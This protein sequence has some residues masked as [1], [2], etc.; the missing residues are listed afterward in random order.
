MLRVVLHNDSASCAAHGSE[1]ARLGTRIYSVGTGGAVDIKEFAEAMAK[2]ETYND[3]QRLEWTF[4]LYD[5]D[6]G[7]TLSLQVPV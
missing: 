7:G 6:S 1:F 2:V 4:S 3:E 5:T